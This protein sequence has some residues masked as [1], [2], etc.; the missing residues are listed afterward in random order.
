MPDSD[1]ERALA[2]FRQELLQKERAAAGK[3]VRVYGEAWGRIQSELARLDVEYQAIKARGGKPGAE[4]IYEYNR[5]RSF[6]LQ[7]EDELRRFAAFAE[8]STRDQMQAA[9]T[10][11]EEHAEKLTR[12]A[13]G[14]GPDGVLIPWNRMPAGAVEEAVGLTSAD[15]PLHPL[16]L[17]IGG[18]GARAA[19]DALVQGLLMGFNPRRTAPLL[20]EALGVTLSRALR[21]ARTQTLRAYRESTRESYRANAD[22]VLG[23]TWSAKLDKRTCASCWAMHGTQHA[24]DERLDD[25]PCGRCGMS[26]VTP[27]WEEL[28]KRFGFDGSGIEET[29]VLQELGS[30]VFVRLSVEDQLKIL[31]PAKWAA[32]KDGKFDLPDLVGRKYDP[33]WGWMRYER[34]L[35]DVVG[36]EAAKGYTRLALMRVAQRAGN[37]SVDDLIRVAGIGLRELTPGE[38]E[39]V[40][41]HVAGAGFDL[42]GL[43]KCGG[44]LSGLVWNGKTLKGSDMLPPGEAHYLRHVVKRQEWPTNTTLNEYYQSLREVIED[45]NSGIVVHKIGSEW[46]IGFLN[47]SGK[48]RGQE[49]RNIIFVDY[50][51]SVSH[52]VT[53]FQPKD[54][55][56]LVANDRWS[57][58]QWIR[59]FKAK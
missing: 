58:V 51:I 38:L 47:S 49:G 32:W 3:M 43:E 12:A 9:I 46:Q 37:Y 53:G 41:R 55:D 56:E 30:A 25:H 40:V 16:L 4:W 28:G 34:S 26:P 57:N 44:R 27:T 18:E 59:P 20:R 54:I 6:R 8:Q 19:E 7:V 42:N 50:R 33:V 11:A 5:A 21:I 35:K 2:Q 36:E 52:W 39:R 17:S 24:L 29:R 1:L 22:V 45:E 14:K 15:S 13:L 48:W 10:A 23:W 31:G